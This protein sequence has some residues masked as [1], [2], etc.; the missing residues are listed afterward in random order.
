MRKVWIIGR[1]IGGVK[2]N[3]LEFL[4]DTNGDYRTFESEEQAAEFLQNCGFEDD[5]IKEHAVIRELFIAIP[6]LR[7]VL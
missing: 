6:N 7:W 5:E 3:P 4:H 2:E 1:H